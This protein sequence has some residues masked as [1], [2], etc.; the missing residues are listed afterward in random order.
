GETYARARALCEQL[1]RPPQIV[2][3]LYGQ[4]AYHLLQGSLRQAREIAV[5]LLQLGEKSEDAALAAMG[6]RLRGMICVQLGEVLAGRTTLEQALAGFDPAHRPFYMSFHVP[7]P[8]AT[9]LTY[10]S[11]DLFCL[12]YLEQA[13]SRSETAIEEAQKLQ[14]SY[15]LGQGLALACFVD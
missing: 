6:P 10:L 14:H 2:P 7:E 11:W 5:E 3:V 15:S 13:R 12:G 9:L 8:L 1:D 4:W